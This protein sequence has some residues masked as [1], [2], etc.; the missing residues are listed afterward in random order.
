MQAR[1][2]AGSTDWTLRYCSISN[3]S[4]CQTSRPLWGLKTEFGN[5]FGQALEQFEDCLEMG[6]RGL[7]KKVGVGWI[8]DLKPVGGSKVPDSGSKPS[9]LGSKQGPLR[10]EST[11]DF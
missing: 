10:L 2:I 6:V 3:E 5:A 11:M 8:G 9:K 1:N 7:R 4:S